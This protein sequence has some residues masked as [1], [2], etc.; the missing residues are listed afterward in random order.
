[1]GERQ[2]PSPSYP[3]FGGFGGGRGGAYGTAGREESPEEW[4]DEMVGGGGTEMG[5]IERGGGVPFWIGGTMAASET[6]VGTFPL[7]TVVNMM[8]IWWWFQQ[9]RRQPRGARRWRSNAFAVNF[10]RPTHSAEH[11]GYGTNRDTLL[12]VICE[13]VLKWIG[14]K[15]RRRPTPIL[16]DLEEEEEEHMGE[17]GG[18]SR[19]KSGRMKWS[20][21]EEKEGRKWDK[22]KG[23]A[24]CHFGWVAQWRRVRQ[25]TA[26][27]RTVSQYLETIHQRYGVVPSAAGRSNNAQQQELSRTKDKKAGE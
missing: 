16:A 22:S 21:E 18:K 7:S 19:R 4:E 6:T 10:W 14:D 26:R 8:R 3:N 2:M 23:A 1:M 20:E 9:Q 12:R 11:L 25:R 15:C 13:G 24:E 17:Q 5:Q 27:E